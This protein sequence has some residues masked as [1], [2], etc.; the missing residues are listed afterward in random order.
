MSA[1]YSVTFTKLINQRYKYKDYDDCT[2]LHHSCSR[3]NLDVIQLLLDEGKKQFVDVRNIQ[4]RSGKSPLFYTTSSKVVQMFLSEG[5][6]GLTIVKFREFG[7]PLLH[8]CV[9]KNILTQTIWYTLVSQREMEF[10]G[11]TA[12]F[13]ADSSHAVERLLELTSLLEGLKL[14]DN[15]GEPLLHHC[16]KTDI[17][18]DSIWSVLVHQRVMSLF[19]A[20]TSSAVER[21]LTLSSTLEG[22]DLVSNHG[23]PLLHPLTLEGCDLV[24]NNGKPL[25]HHCMK[26]DILTNIIWSVLGIQRNLEYK[27]KSAVFHACSSAAV[28]MVLSSGLEGLKLVDSYGEPLLHYCMKSHIHTNKRDILTDTIWSVLDIQRKMEYQGQS[29]VFHAHSS[30]AVEM[31]L[32]SGL[33][34]LK[35][36]DRNGEPLLHHCVR[37]GILTQSI[38]DTLE[39]QRK[40]EYERKTVIEL[41]ENSNKHI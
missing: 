30:A 27:G 40:M 23:E 17:L 4:E 11:K 9:R 22:C 34:G 32:S 29:A 10:E 5:L 13:H 33:E 3:N 26:K 8:Y 36:V 14:V 24:S 7:E 31:F 20:S 25:L 41:G 6:E 1:Y 38:W 39:C 19:Y 16:V 15:N 21:L 37:Y 12:A 35:L 28:E 2:P 18:T